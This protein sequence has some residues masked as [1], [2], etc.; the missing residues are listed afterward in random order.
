[1][2]ACLNS[3]ESCELLDRPSRGFF[4]R[5]SAC[6]E[7]AKLFRLTTRTQLFHS[8]KR[9]TI[10][11]AKGDLSLVVKVL[12]NYIVNPFLSDDEHSTILL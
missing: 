5:A 12:K 1:M 3:H 9:Q 7:K 4:I 10:L 6:T 8:D 11:L 2:G